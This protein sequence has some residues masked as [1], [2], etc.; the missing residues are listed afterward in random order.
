MEFRRRTITPQ[1]RTCNSIPHGASITPPS[2]G[3][4]LDWRTACALCTVT[5]N[6]PSPRETSNQHRHSTR[7]FGKTSAPTIHAMRTSPH[8]APLPLESHVHANRTPNLCAPRSK[9][10]YRACTTTSVEATAGSRPTSTLLFLH[11]TPVRAR[12]P[13]AH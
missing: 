6:I 5:V 7:D 4:L 1:S 11:Y 2:R 12:Q 8:G 13:Q 10:S 9:K 3:K